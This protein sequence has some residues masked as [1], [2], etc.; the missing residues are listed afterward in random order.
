MKEELNIN[1]KPSAQSSPQSS[2]KYPW[3]HTKTSTSSYY[4]QEKNFEDSSQ[5]LHDKLVSHYSQTISDS[6]QNEHHYNAIQPYTSG[7]SGMNG[8]L[9][10]HKGTPESD[11]DKID[12]HERRIK[13]LMKR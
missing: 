6:E 2:S 13:R 10:Q 11:L 7:S 9:L 8:Y 4:G 3:P 1:A 12:F 5:G